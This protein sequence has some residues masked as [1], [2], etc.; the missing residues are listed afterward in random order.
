MPRPPPRGSE[1]GGGRS[2]EPG[3]GGEADGANPAHGGAGGCPIRLRGVRKPAEGGARSRATAAKP[4][5][6]T[7]RTVVPADAPSASAGFGSRRRAEPGAGPRRRSRRG[8]PRARWG[9]RMPHP[10]PRGSE[11]G[12][13]RGPEPG[14]GG[15]ADGANPAHGGAGGCPIR[16]RGVR[17]PA[18][19]AV[20]SRATAA[21]P[22]GRT[23]RTVGPADAPSASAGFGSRRRAR[24]GAGPRRRS[25]RG[26][27]RAACGCG[28][29]CLAKRA[30]HRT[31]APHS[32]ILDRSRGRGGNREP[33]ARRARRRR[34][35]RHRRARGRARDPAGGAGD[36]RE[37]SASRLSRGRRS[38]FSGT[39]STA[40]GE[41]ATGGGEGADGHRAP[42]QGPPRRRRADRPRLGQP[43]HLDRGLDDEPDGPA[44]VLRAGRTRRRDLRASC[45]GGGGHSPPGGSGDP[46]RSGGDP[47]RLRA[48]ER[49][50][51]PHPARHPGRT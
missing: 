28:S 32:A 26:E 6:R 31:P 49:D 45:A 50:H 39:A 7:P 10:P 33:P 21:K 46:A 16:L 35:R 18:E 1:A 17:K 23:P 14:H 3:H 24:P 8:E 38:E 5:G 47:A 41:P 20:R 37:R 11:A 15:E 51:L 43:R 12:G 25:R 30:W 2:P 40:R 29:E 9:R 48:L 34:G 27:P 13:G 44:G 19:G 22:T 36:R 4:T 42:W